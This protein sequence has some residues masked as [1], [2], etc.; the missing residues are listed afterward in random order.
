[1]AKKRGKIKSKKIK[2]SKKS[3]H[4][5]IITGIIVLVAIGIYATILTLIDIGHSQEEI[6]VSIDNCN[7]ILKDAISGEWLKGLSTSTLSS[8]DCLSE[9]EFPKKYHLASEIIVTINSYTLTLQDVINRNYFKG[10]GTI[11]SSSSS[12]PSEG[13]SATKVEV[14]IDG[15]K[16]TLQEALSDLKYTC[17]SNYNQDCP[18]GDV[19]CINPGSIQCEG[20][21][22]GTY[23]TSGTNCGTNMKCDTSGNCVCN[24]GWADCNNDNSCECD[25]TSK[26]CSAG[27]CVVTV[28]C[29]TN[30]SVQCYDDD[31][32]WYDSCGVRE[33]KKE[34]C[35]SDYCD[36]WGEEYCVGEVAK[37]DRICH[38]LGC[39]GDACFDVTYT[40]TRNVFDNPGDSKI[41]CTK[42]AIEEEAGDGKVICTEFYNLGYL[43]E[44]TYK[45]DLEYAHSHFSPE[46]IKGYQAWA[47]PGV[48]AMRKNP[49]ETKEYIVPLI[50]SF[51]EE[52]AYRVGKRETRNEVGALF[53]DRG[54]PLFERIGVHINE[55]DWKSL[56]ET[57]INPLYLNFIE[58]AIGNNFL[59]TK[60]LIIGIFQSD[61][62]NEYDDLVRNYFTEEKL[63]E[64][65]YD[66][67]EKSKGSDIE[68]ANALL[69]NLEEAVE[70]I[71][72]IVEAIEKSY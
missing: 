60:S 40:D 24:T 43:D 53:L 64:M 49:E 44:A 36:A 51:M 56:F 62:E 65:Y 48:K 45:M 68:F 14:T 18:S 31:V 42:L 23:K 70:E 29:E 63:K 21:C 37:H 17:V 61:T 16:K 10:T 7:V 13:H 57:Q 5:L 33:E 59:S 67:K 20:S 34:E 19:A 28:T 22:S 8:S 27:S 12:L 55:P 66:A 39:D 72:S 4:T 30:D 3:F 50:N 52:V 46:A 58:S 1:M 47:I 69:D 11:S 6:I 15:T 41:F 54:L 32:Y 26:Q 9:S 35:G 25:L 2:F 38:V 71:E